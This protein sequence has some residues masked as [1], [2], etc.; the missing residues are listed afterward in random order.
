MKTKHLHI[1]EGVGRKCIAHARLSRI[2]CAMNTVDCG[3]AIGICAAPSLTRRV[4]IG[5]RWLTSRL[6]YNAFVFVTAWQAV[7]R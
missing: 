7:L 2:A 3:L 4:L 5:N 1:Y 6:S